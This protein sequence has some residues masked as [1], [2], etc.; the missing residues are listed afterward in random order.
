MLIERDALELLCQTDPAMLI[1][2][3]RIAHIV[4]GLYSNQSNEALVR[5]RGLILEIAFL[6]FLDLCFH[7]VI[8]K[9]IQL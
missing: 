6:D 9:V 5:L 8:H 3:I 2:G 4:F 7:S 1:L